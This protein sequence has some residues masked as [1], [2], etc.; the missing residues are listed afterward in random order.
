MTTK[1][2]VKRIINSVWTITYKEVSPTEVEIF[3]YSRDDEEGYE[4]EHE[5]P[6][7]NI[8]EDKERYDIEIKVDDKQFKVVNPH[9]VFDYP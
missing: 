6:K 2:A 1:K 7:G 3:R 9:H 8:I 5:L 4:K